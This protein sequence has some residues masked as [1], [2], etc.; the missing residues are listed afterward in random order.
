MAGPGEKR[1]AQ[2]AQGSEGRARP[3]AENPAPRQ[4]CLHLPHTVCP[5]LCLAGIPQTALPTGGSCCYYT[6]FRDGQNDSEATQYRVHK[7]GKSLNPDL[8]TRDGFQ[9][10]ISSPQPWELW[11]AGRGKDTPSSQTKAG[12]PA[13]WM[14]GT[15]MGLSEPLFWK[16]QKKPWV[17]GGLFTLCFAANETLESPLDCKETKP[18]HPKGN[19]P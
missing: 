3:P 11:G 7:A 8:N 14:A 1:G 5:A 10:P 6:H 15:R 4:L 9:R 13:L 18:A 2:Q 12:C 17:Q 16:T 19:Q